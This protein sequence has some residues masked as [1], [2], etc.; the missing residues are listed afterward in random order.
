MNKIHISIVALVALFVS[1]CWWPGIR[2]NGHIVTDKRP[3]TEF[4][5]IKAGGMFEIEWHPGA[6]SLS[7]TTDD[8][9]LSYIENRTEG[10]TLRLET[11]DQIRPT[12]RI[13]LLVTSPNLTGVSISGAV[14]LNATQLSG[15]KFYLDTSGACHII[16]AGNVDDLLAEM[17]GA[18]KLEAKDLHTKNADISSSGASKADVFASETLRVSIS[19][20]GKVTY[21][22]H[23][24][25]ERHITGA[26]SINP[27]D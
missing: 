11:R 13:K 6:P 16:L 20:A 14:R 27:G 19:G 12:R 3:V 4:S 1:C 9:L 26:G 17:S 15:P 8:N 25:I 18:T 7:I 5:D 21:F 2:G 22:G 10:K 23:P 24:K